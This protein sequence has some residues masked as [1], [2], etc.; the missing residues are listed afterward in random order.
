MPIFSNL[1]GTCSLTVKVEWGVFIVGALDPKQGERVGCHLHLEK[2]FNLFA[3]SRMLSTIGKQNLL[4]SS[5]FLE[6]AWASCFT[7]DHSWVEVVILLISWHA[8][9]TPNASGNLYLIPPDVSCTL[10][11]HIGEGQ[12]FE[13]K[14]N[15][16]QKCVDKNFELM[17]CSNIGCAGLFCPLPVF[18]LLTCFFL[19]GLK[20][21]YTKK[22]NLL[23]IWEQPFSI[24]TQLLCECR[25]YLYCNYK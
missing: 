19:S 13:L 1:L 9:S 7:I 23:F 16:I 5:L 4:Y 17:S 22:M 12:L 15:W 18:L 20:G 6:W 10:F 14:F 24:G 11:M 8:A 3:L 2:G 25:F 21:Y